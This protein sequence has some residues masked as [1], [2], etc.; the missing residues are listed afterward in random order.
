MPRDQLADAVAMRLSSSGHL[1]S[2]RRLREGLEPDPVWSAELRGLE[3]QAGSEVQP[4]HPQPLGL[5]KRELRR[6]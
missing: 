5:A 3:G 2:D 6:S 1:R 4:G